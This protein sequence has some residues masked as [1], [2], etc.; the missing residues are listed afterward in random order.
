MLTL[1][2]I[3]VHVTN[4]A[5]VHGSASTAA[6]VLTIAGA[7]LALTALWIGTRFLP[8][9]KQQPALTIAQPAHP[10]VAQVSRLAATRP[11]RPT[12]AARTP[13]AR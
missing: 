9:G 3:S 2:G 5:P 1:L 12:H 6:E 4:N 8:R 11:G 7:V 13:L 10:E